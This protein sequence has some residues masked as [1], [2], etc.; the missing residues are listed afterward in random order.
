MFS[1]IKIEK[2]IPVPEIKMT[3]HGG[4]WKHLANTMEV[5]DSVFLKQPPRDKKGNLS[6]IPRLQRYKPKKFICQPENKGARI[7]RVA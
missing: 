4:L 1:D 5:G 3:R 2:D 6:I 7:W